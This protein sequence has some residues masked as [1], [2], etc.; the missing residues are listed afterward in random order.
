V[1]VIDTGSGATAPSSGPF[2]TFNVNA[3]NK[4]EIVSFVTNPADPAPFQSYVATA[5]IHCAPPDTQVTISIVGTDGFTS[6]STAI[7]QGDA[8]ATLFVPGAEE[9]V[10]DTVTVRVRNGPTRQIVLVF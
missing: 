8:N 2:P 10:V 6:S 5:Q 3:G 4:V 1:G 9:G 7:I